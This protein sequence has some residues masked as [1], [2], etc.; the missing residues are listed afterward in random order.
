MI[1]K[2][3][4]FWPNFKLMTSQHG[5]RI[6]RF[7]ENSFID[8]RLTS[9]FLFLLIFIFL[10][11]LVHEIRVWTLFSSQFWVDNVIMLSQ[12]LKIS[13]E[14]FHKRIIH[15][16]VLFTFDF[17][18]SINIGTWNTNLDFFDSF[19]GWWRFE[20]VVSK[21]NT[22]SQIS[23]YY[24]LS[25]FYPHWYMKHKFGPFLTQ[26]WVNDVNMGVKT[27]ILW[28]SDLRNK[29]LTSK[30][31][32]ILIS[33]FLSPSIHDTQRWSLFTKFG[34]NDVTKEIIIPEFWSINYDL[35]KMPMTESV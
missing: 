15:C 5:A 22:S 32:Q 10:S 29:P 35:L 12:K 30:F 1:Y 24:R 7:R 25:S 34:D 6:S 26:F 14:R 17:H 4:C 13:R 33:I 16:K 28:Q 20:T 2:L 18:L 23:L 11:P 21:T 19:L 8:K 9:K 27:A 31:P 3:E